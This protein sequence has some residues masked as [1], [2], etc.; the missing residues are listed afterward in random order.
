MIEL[1]IVPFNSRSRPLLFNCLFNKSVYTK[2]KQLFKRKGDRLA[3]PGGASSTSKSA[4]FLFF[5]RYQ[6]RSASKGDP[7]RVYLIHIWRLA[8][9]N[10]WSF[11]TVFVNRSSSLVGTCTRTDSDSECRRMFFKLKKRPHKRPLSSTWAV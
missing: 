9:Y 3:I 8:N 7:N 5:P 1:S 10:I 6:R 4:R 11:D 2:E